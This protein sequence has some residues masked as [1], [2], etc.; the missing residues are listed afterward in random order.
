MI[1][2]NN[3]K[4]VLILGKGKTGQSVSNWFMKNHNNIK[5]VLVIESDDVD[6]ILSRNH[7]D[8]AIQSPGISF[9]HPLRLKIDLKKIPVLTDIDLFFMTNPNF[10]IG[11]TGTNGKSTTASLLF[12][13]FKECQI[14]VFLGGNIGVPVLDLP[15]AKNSVYI[16]ELSSYQ[17]YLSKTHLFLASCIL[18]IKPDH[19]EWHK[20]MEN[21]RQ[22]K[23]KIFEKSQIKVLNPLSLHL[24]NPFLKGEH[25]L[26]N[27]QMCF[28]LIEK[29]K[30]FIKGK[31]NY[32]NLYPL[33]KNDIQSKIESFRGLAHRL[34]IVETLHVNNKKINKIIF[35]NDSKA[36][37]AD[38][39]HVALST[40]SNSLIFWIAGGRPKSEGIT[41]L[42]RFFAS[43]QGAY[44][45][46]EA[47]HEFKNNFCQSSSLIQKCFIFDSLDYAFEKSLK[48]ALSL[49]LDS[50]LPQKDIVILLSPA[51]SSFDQ[52]ENFE[53]RGDYFKM[54]VQKQ[55][56]LLF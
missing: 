35:I 7:F 42:S 8:L 46:G 23:Y 45:F 44:F 20:T 34:E 13:V 38:S 39:V 18:N 54:C 3:I 50:S 26:F 12:H 47:K 17:L 40:F 33:F 28:T 15:M 30:E 56:K 41:R 10:V 48:D 2:F 14:N 16:F 43:I 52:F 24:N 36:T 19:L 37:N 11:I 31:K 32:S 55:L 6:R 27:M 1:D 51:C 21:Y 29:I 53:K 5:V 49:A 9:D 22:S 25:N 4:S